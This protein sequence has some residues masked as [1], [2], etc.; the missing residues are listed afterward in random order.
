MELGFPMICPILRG[1]SI[2][3]T[4]DRPS[5]KTINDVIQI[6]FADRYFDQKD[7]KSAAEK[8]S[9]TQIIND[10]EKGI[11]KVLE[12]LQKV[13]PYKVQVTAGVY[14]E[15]YFTIDYLA[16]QQLNG[17]IIS[18]QDYTQVS[19][20]IPFHNDYQTFLKKNLSLSKSI[21]DYTPTNHELVIVFVVLNVQ[22]YS[23]DN[24]DFD[25]FIEGDKFG[26]NKTTYLG[27]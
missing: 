15:D 22:S 20:L 19:T 16:H 26:D 6:T 2:E 7:S 5:F 13:Q 25:Y 18:Y 9:K 27:K 24:G 8:R 10:A 1:G 12:Y 4:N 23:C 3:F 21:I 14:I 17:K 11:L